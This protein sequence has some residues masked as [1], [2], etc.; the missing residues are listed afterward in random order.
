[1][2]TPLVPAA[3]LAF[4]SHHFDSLVPSVQRA[5]TVR[6]ASLDDFL[7]R[8]SRLPDGFSYGTTGTPTHRHL[9]ARI[10]AL[11]GARHGLVLP[12]G[13]A[14][15][16]LVMLHRLSQ[17]DHLLISASSYGPAVTFAAQHLGRLG[18][19]V[20]PY[21]PR[22]GG[23]IRRLFR[24]T[25]R[26]VWMES[27]GS[28]TMEVQDVAAMASAARQA[29]IATAIDN[30]WSSPLYS[31]PLDLGVDL[32][33]H[34]CT[35]YMGGHSDLLMGSVTTRDDDL[36]AGLRQMQAYMGQAAGTDDCFLVERGLDTLAIRMQA[37]STRALALADW[38]QRHPAVADVLHPGLPDSRDHALWQRQSSGCGAVFSFLPRAQGLA[39]AQAFFAGLRQF[40]IG[41]SWGSVHS[42]AA[43]YPAALQTGRAF[44]DVQGPLIRLSIGLEDPALLQD[45]LAQALHRMQLAA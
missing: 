19:Q 38:L 30:T 17:G 45:D 16:A 37:Q 7:A 23:D 26:L 33:L 4:N 41:A 12:S 34:A 42:L 1:M 22:V 9:E 31:R 8:G 24:P 11:D 13:Q 21:D 44:C 15:I 25:T 36:Y 43:Y 35:K 40:A 20:E 18:V 29:G 14:A 32:C 6:F 2:S 28:L 10:A 3:G 39:A 5:S 27:P